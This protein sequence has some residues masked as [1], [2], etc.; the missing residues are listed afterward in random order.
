MV[1]GE[2]TLSDTEKFT[3]LNLK[4]FFAQYKSFVER[5]YP[6]MVDYYQGKTNN[7]NA[8]TINA[9]NSLVKESNRIV[10]TLNITIKDLDRLDYWNLLYFIDEIYARNFTLMVISKWLRSSKYEGFN[11]DS[12]IMEYVTQNFDTPETVAGIDRPNPQDD[13]V[14]I[15][16]KNHVYETDYQAEEGGL[17]LNIGRKNLG[18][19]QLNSVVDNLIGENMYGKDISLDFSYADDD[20]VVDTPRET[21]KQAVLIL[22]QLKKGE[23]PEVPELGISQEL[24]LGSTVGLLN[25]PFIERE[26]SESFASDDTITNYTIDNVEQQSGVVNIEFS[27]NSFFNLVESANV[28]I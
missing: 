23:I 13:W 11:E 18:G 1:L 19:L 2:N 16:V 25:L 12:L 3:G 28:E 27:C 14:D 5:Y 9:F 15:Y 24:A 21:F 20:V 22:A 8:N 10:D 6:N 7:L 26:I 4:R 17:P